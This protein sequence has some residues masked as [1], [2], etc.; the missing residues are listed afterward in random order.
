MYQYNAKLK[1][2]VF[3]NLQYYLT[4]VRKVISNVDPNANVYLF[5]SIATGNYNMA[6]DIDILIV[7]S[8]ERKIIQSSLDR[9]GLGFPFEF[10]IRTEKESE[11][12]FIHIK[13]MKLI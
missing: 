5:G 7:T 10:H 8:V 13:E 3:T 11:P 9:E 1:K 2:E 4:K 12:Y 6:S